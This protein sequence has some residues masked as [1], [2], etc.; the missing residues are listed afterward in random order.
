MKIYTKTG[1]RGETS[2]LGGRRVSKT[3]IRIEAYGTVDE[4]N[5]HLGLLRDYEISR[6]LK[7]Q[8]LVIQNELFDM[9]AYLACEDDPA[10]FQISLITEEQIHRLESEIDDMEKQLKPL[11]NFI[12]PGG[13]QAVSQ[14]HIARCICRRVERNVLKV[15]ETESIDH[16]VIRYLNRLSDYLFIMARKLAHDFGIDEIAWK[17]SKNN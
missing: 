4:L 17:S 15:N 13:H 3:D 5:S 1:D 16:G 12:L 9:G 2:L 14:C 8:L 7:N 6:E 10:R 11:K